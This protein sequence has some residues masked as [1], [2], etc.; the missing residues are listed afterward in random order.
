MQSNSSKLFANTAAV[1]LNP[2]LS[3][4]WAMATLPV[5]SWQGVLILPSPCQWGLSSCQAPS[6]CLA[7]K[8]Q[9][10]VFVVPGQCHAER[11][12]R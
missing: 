9:A 5:G 7:A 6:L 3:A 12:L 11:T 8:L 4:V 10:F 2:L 1:Y